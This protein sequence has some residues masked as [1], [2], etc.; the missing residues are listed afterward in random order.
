MYFGSADQKLYAIEGISGP[1]SNVWSK[2]RG[3][4]R[5]TGSRE[6][7]GPAVILSLPAQTQVALGHS[8]TV[9]ASVGGTR[10]FHFQWL[11]NGQPIPDA[12]NAQLCLKQV[13]FTDAGEYS[14]IVSNAA[15]TARS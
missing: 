6:I 2:F 3:D 15:G 13:R 5:N 8:T 7:E 9:A 14:I 10:P 11:L 12:M 1:A 4:E